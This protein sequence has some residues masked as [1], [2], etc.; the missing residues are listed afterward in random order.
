MGLSDCSRLYFSDQRAIQ[1]LALLDL[2]PIRAR[3]S[4]RNPG[5]FDLCSKCSL[6]VLRPT[7]SLTTHSSPLYFSPVSSVRDL[8]SPSPLTCISQL[9]RL[10][11]VTG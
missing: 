9:T 10:P 6:A 3:F 11:S 2:M 5:L 7:L 1:S 8:D 4:Q